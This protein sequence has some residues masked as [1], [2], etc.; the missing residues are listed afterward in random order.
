MTREQE[1]IDAGRR[2]AL[3][4]CAR[5]ADAVAEMAPQ[6]RNDPGGYYPAGLR[7][8]AKEIS[9]AIRAK[10]SGDLSQ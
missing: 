5:V 8:A 10:L 7:D 1:L 9:Q 6:R 4:E 3:E 2:G